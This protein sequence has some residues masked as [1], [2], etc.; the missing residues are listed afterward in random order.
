[1]NTS[2]L[3]TAIA[4]TGMAC[5]FPGAPDLR[6]FWTNLCT[7]VDAIERFDIDELRRAG[8]ADEL[9]RDPS[10]VPA[11]APIPDPFAFDAAH[12]GIASATARALDLQHRVFL[13][14]AWLALE[15][16]GTPAARRHHVAVFAGCSDTT[17]ASLAHPTDDG[18]AGSLAAELGSSSDFLAARVAFSLDLRGPA[19]T[20]RAACATSLVAVHLA[21]QSLLTHECDVAVTG[22]A[23]IRHPLRRGHLYEPGGIYSRDGR[24][25]PYDH[26]GSGIV[27]GDGAGAV[28]LRRLED[29]VADGDPIH[30]I[31]LGTAVTNDGLRK[32]SFTA[33]SVEGQV[34]AARVALEVADCDPSAIGFVE[35]HGTATPLGDPLEVE[36]LKRVWAM[37]ASRTRPC[38]LGSVKSG[39]GHLDAAAGIAGLI[40]ACLAVEHARIPGTLNYSA[41]N[42][43]AGLDDSPFVVSADTVDWHGDDPRRAS[44]HSLGLGGTNAHVVLEQAPL[45][46]RERLISVPTMPVVLTISTQRPDAMSS[47]AKALAASISTLTDDVATA[48]HTLQFGRTA[49]PYRRIVVGSD[50]EALARGLS[51]VDAPTRLASTQPRVVVAF[52]GDGRRARD[53]LVGLAEHLGPVAATLQTAANHLRARWDIDMFGALESEGSPVGI[54]PAI[55][56]QSV[57]L[58]AALDHFG[59]GGDLVIGQSLGELSAAVASGIIDL[60]QALDLAVAREHVFRSAVASG[61]VAVGLSPTAVLERLPADLEL[62]LV[63]SPNRCVVSGRTNVLER[64]AAE[65]EAEQVPVQRLDLI[66]APHSSLLDPYVAE[67]RRAAARLEPRHPTRAFL[68][69]VGPIEIGADEV[70]NPDHWARQLRETV[71]FD[72]CLRAALSSKADT[73][74]V[75]AS[76]SGSLTACIRETLGDDVRAVVKVSG[77]AD[78][79]APLESFALA[80]GG[81]W[82]Q[83]VAIEWEAWPRRAKQQ[84]SLP[85]P[86]LARTPHEPL[87][88]SRGRRTKPPRAAGA[89]ELWSRTWQ[90][91]HLPSSSARS[92][93]IVVLA[94]ADPMCHQLGAR[95]AQLGHEVQVSERAM[96]SKIEAPID[97]IVDARALGEHHGP[98][99]TTA[100]LELVGALLERDGSSARLAVLTRGAFDIVGDELLSASAAAVAAAALVITQEHGELDLTCLDLPSQAADLSLVARLLAPE[101]N[102]RGGWLGLRGRAVWR[103]SV[104]LV[105]AHMGLEQPAFTDGACVIIGGLGR[106][107]RWVGRWLA[108]A[109]C[110]HV[111]LIGRTDP[112]PGPS[113]DA[114]ATMRRA[115]ARVTVVPADIGDRVAMAKLLDDARGSVAGRM[116]IFHLAGQP[117]APSAFAPLTDLIAGDVRAALD[118]QWD[119][120][121]GG[122]LVLL[123]WTR[124][125][126]DTRCVVFSSNAAVLGGLGLVAYAAANAAVD[127][128]A[129]S[130]REHEALDWCSIG[131]DGWRLPDDDAGSTPTA[132][133][134]FALHGDEP[135]LALRAAVAAAR[136]H[137]VVAKGDLDERYRTWVEQPTRLAAKT[138]PLDASRTSIRQTGLD[139]VELVRGIWSEILGF[140]PG[141]DVD[142]FEAGGDSLTAMRIRTRI[143]RVLGV[144]LTLQEVLQNRTVAKLAAMAHAADSD[145]EMNATAPATETSAVDRIIRGRL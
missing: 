126:P 123:D 89:V 30:A 140:V 129:T 48:A 120:K 109:G 19:V 29:A 28:V 80:L 64:F 11:C 121:V 8:V 70:A 39:I 21:V 124:R 110:P 95:L 63:N 102:Q 26:L 23:A 132:L 138:N 67:Y 78:Q 24:C 106:F 1:M 137:V 77:Q 47:Y 3:E 100:L 56:A 96:C 20:V 31:I 84:V 118:E 105:R 18:Q 90:R 113:V 108:E 112:S 4:V 144:R 34:E 38:V 58:Y 54:I 93:R 27:S 65:L 60:E 128:L 15:S 97:L 40:K 115:G 79:L 13:E 133:E 72:D 49:A 135:W 41:P 119:A 66:S 7:G 101:T 16:S 68:S 9:L 81:L 35:G 17:W 50:R 22:A 111:Y 127:A 59:A 36:A 76:L 14:C 73:V 46:K 52:S 62:S 136:G 45:V 116:T 44:V 92:Q 131:W 74:M 55:V 2:R 53:T 51:C 25:R 57:A 61:A 145:A 10:F 91:T 104:E 99:A 12:F 107:G 71:R 87:G 85:V 142:L 125:H 103:S 75:D 139:R 33:P 114:I 37:G 134:S 98:V 69:C 43:Q 6:T 83:G 122:A 32:A 130:A 82:E 94:G 42:P 117:H 141:D 5:R 86:P 88:S 143:E